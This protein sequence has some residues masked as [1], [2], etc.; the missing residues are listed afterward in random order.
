[1]L[2]AWWCRRGLDSKA[3]SYS[4]CRVAESVLVAKNCFNP[5]IRK[6]SLRWVSS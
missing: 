5:Y 1:M 2:Q 4:D 6:A 3:L